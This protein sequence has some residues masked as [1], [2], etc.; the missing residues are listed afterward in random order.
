MQATSKQY[1][2][3]PTIKPNYSFPEKRRKTMSRNKNQN[4][5]LNIRLQPP[6]NKLINDKLG[7]EGFKR[8]FTSKFF[9][10]GGQ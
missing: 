7:G 3:Q 4:Q 10:I 9:A 1:R 8:Q 2:L 6:K 5:K